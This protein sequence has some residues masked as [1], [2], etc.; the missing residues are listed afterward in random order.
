MRFDAE[1]ATRDS[2][3]EAC[4]SSFVAPGVD[5]DTPPRRSTAPVAAPSDPE[6]PLYLGIP[7]TDSRDALLTAVPSDDSDPVSATGPS[8]SRRVLRTYS[9]T[10]G[11]VS[12]SSVSSSSRVLVPEGSPLVPSGMA[13]EQPAPVPPVGAELPNSMP[14]SA[15]PPQD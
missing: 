13:H 1:A 15:A 12:G 10:A 2:S 14:T 5:L 6:P 11:S 4:A 8:G 3:A 9:S 7:V